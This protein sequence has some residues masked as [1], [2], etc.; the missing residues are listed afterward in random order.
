MVEIYNKSIAHQNKKTVLNL[1]KYDFNLVF[2]EPF[3]PH[4]K[5]ELKELYEKVFLKVFN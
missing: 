5:A 3:H 2:D 4:I 1:V